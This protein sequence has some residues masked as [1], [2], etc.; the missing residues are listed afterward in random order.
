MTRRERLERAVAA[1]VAAGYRC[2]ECGDARLETEDD[3]PVSYHYAGPSPEESCP[4]NSGGIA[5]WQSHNDVWDW[6]EGA[7]PGIAADYGEVSVQRFDL[8]VA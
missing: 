1:A 4:V 5:A 3:R 7:D 6:L 8:V 2:I